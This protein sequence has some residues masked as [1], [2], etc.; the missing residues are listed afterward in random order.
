MGLGIIHV[1]SNLVMFNENAYFLPFLILTRVRTYNRVPCSLLPNVRFR[2]IILQLCILYILSE[3]FA[4]VTLLLARPLSPVQGK[5]DFL[6]RFK[7]KL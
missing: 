7:G 4:L 5:V 6:N 1:A 3:S 2:H